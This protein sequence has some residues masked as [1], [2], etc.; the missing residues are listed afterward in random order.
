M[1]RF[2]FAVLGMVVLSG[3]TSTS[4]YRWGDYEENLF[5][6]YHKPS[7]QNQVVASH[8]QF[9]AQLEQEN[10]KPAPGLL[11]EAGTLLLLQ[12]KTREAITYYQ[13]EH[14]AW[15]ESQPMMSALITNL[16]E[17]K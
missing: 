9:L 16:K 12:G 3:C 15:P 11:A 7:L 8:L 2:T 14:D 6:Y 1:I 17:R 10:V 5:S 13:K 4:L